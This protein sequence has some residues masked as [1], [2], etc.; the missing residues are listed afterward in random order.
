MKNQGSN[1][2]VTR[3]SSLWAVRCSHV[4][5]SLEN[6]WKTTLYLET[7]LSSFIKSTNFVGAS[8]TFLMKR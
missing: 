7:N 6:H 2:P 1:I 3:V 4:I 8:N 5:G